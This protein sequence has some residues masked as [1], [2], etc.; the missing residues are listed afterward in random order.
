MKNI[1]HRSLLLV[2]IMFALF[3]L[4]SAS[5]CSSY[6]TPSSTAVSTP[7]SGS[8]VTLSNFAFSPAT[9]TVKV[10]ATVTWINKDSATHNITS[11]TGVFQSGS[12][13]TNAAFS[14]KFNTPGTFAYHCSIHP[15]MKATVIVQ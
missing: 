1:L 9:L 5:A 14:Y 15:S 8:S 6:G 3:V 13:A 10:G 11:D 12:M 4:V 7:A 2:S